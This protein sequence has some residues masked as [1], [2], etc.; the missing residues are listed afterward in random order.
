MWLAH[1]IAENVLQIKFHG[2]TAGRGNAEARIQKALSGP[3]TVVRVVIQSQIVFCQQHRVSPKPDIDPDI[4][5]H[6]VVA[7]VILKTAVRADVNAR[8][9]REPHE[10]F[11][12]NDVHAL[13]LFGI[14]FQLLVIRPVSLRR[15]AH[16]NARHLISLFQ[17]PHAG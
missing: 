15:I 17:H 14:A 1:A 3:Q 9:P 2:K 8:V 7:V 10:I 12:G 5:R 4:A 16:R 13:G 11:A 6:R